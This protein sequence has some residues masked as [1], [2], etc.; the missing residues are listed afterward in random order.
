[1]I[2]GKTNKET[3]SAILTA[4]WHLMETKP[5]CRTDDFWIAQWRKVDFVSDLQ[6]QYDCPVIHSGDL[7]E[8]WKSSPS[9]L[10]E[11]I[12]HLPKQFYTVLGNHDLPQHNLSLVEKSGVYTLEQAGSL[13]ILK[14]LHWGQKEF[15]TPPTI[16]IDNRY[17]LVWHS[18]TYVGKPPYPGCL[19]P[20]ASNLLKKFEKFQLDLILTGHNHQAFIA[21][22]DGRLLIN[23]GSLT[24]Q[25]ADQMDFEP[26][27]YLYYAESNTVKPI[28]L[29]IEEGVISREHLDIVEKRNDRIDAFINRLDGDWNITMSFEENLKAF[30]Q[31]NNVHESVKNLVYNAIEK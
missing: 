15:E 17:I 16:E 29:P 31:A 22:L 14:G 8:Y 25:T 27:V 12:K 2:R 30:F 20:T 7:Y 24:R 28:Y 6:K 26:R 23:P 13:K 5:V 10:S 11:T 18:M 9:L 19:D 21:E 4:D 1:M 3:V